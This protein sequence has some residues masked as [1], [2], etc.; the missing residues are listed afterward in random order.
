[1]DD[2]LLYRV[3]EVAAYLS[4]SRSKVYELLKSG[5]LPSVHIDRTRRVRKSDL[6]GYV[7]SLAAAS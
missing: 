6:E 2:K 3:P 4:I 7:D 1:M 5:E